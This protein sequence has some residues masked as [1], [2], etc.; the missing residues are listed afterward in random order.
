MS[1]KLDEL[2]SEALKLSS[3]E[4]MLLA[5]ALYAST[6]ADVEFD[7]ADLREIERRYQEL[8]SGAVRGESLEEVIADLRAPLK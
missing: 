2:T 6:E 3:E 4:R 5:D 8:R 7:P 1:T